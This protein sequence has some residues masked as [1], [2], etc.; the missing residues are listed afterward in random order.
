MRAT[1]HHAALE[2][3]AQTAPGCEIVTGVRYVDNGKIITS[4]GITAGIDTS[5]YIVQRLLGAT[6]A[7][8]TARHL[9]Y[10]WEPEQDGV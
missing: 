3:L 2:E 7:L 8:E 9:E 6:T 10:R 4:A 1:T 5:L